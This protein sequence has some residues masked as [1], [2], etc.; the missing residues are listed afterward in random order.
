[1]PPG[2]EP[3]LAGVFDAVAGWWHD[4]PLITQLAIGAGIAALVVLSGGSLGLALGI[5]G[6]LTWGLDHSAGIATFT[7][8]PRQATRDYFATAT[9]A[10]L[11]ADTLGVALTFAPGNFAGAATGRILRST[12]DD[13]AVDP[14]A[15]W[16]A[17]RQNFGHRGTSGADQQ[18]APAQSDVADTFDDVLRPLS[19]V[20]VQALS[21]ALRPAK[22]DHVFVPKH[23]FEPLLQRYGTRENAM[24][25]LVRSLS[26]PDLPTAGR[27]EVTRIVAKQ[28]VIIRGIVINGVPRIGTAFTP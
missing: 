5:S 3:W 8:N 9:P 11:A 7:R 26:G 13:L 16:A 25:Q 22:L 24:E 28:E 1:M 27:F 4:Q 10:Q 2:A 15:W 17:R 23:K 12:A 21:D 6:V 18:A 20:E 14:A 19:Q